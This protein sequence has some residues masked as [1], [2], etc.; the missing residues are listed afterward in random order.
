MKNKT[1]IAIDSSDLNFIPIIIT[2]TIIIIIIIVQI[3]IL[4]EYKSIII[5]AF[6]ML[7]TMKENQDGKF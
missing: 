1:L 3:I 6:I 7:L 2:I 5:P 4:F